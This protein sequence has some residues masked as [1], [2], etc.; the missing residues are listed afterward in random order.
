MP[1]AR[2]VIIILSA[3]AERRKGGGRGAFAADYGEKVE[4]KVRKFT[5]IG[6]A[7]NKFRL[8]ID[9]LDINTKDWHERK[10]S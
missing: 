7:S 5:V 3:H 4:K 10:V 6:T 1:A 2:T 9:Q 8:N